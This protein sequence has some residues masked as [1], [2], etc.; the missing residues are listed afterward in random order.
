MLYFI[1]NEKARSGKGA[2]I[3][4]EVQGILH[5]ENRNYKAWVT[6]YEGHAFSLAKDICEKDDSDICLVVVGGDG[7]ANE[8]INGISHFEKVR[9]GTIPTGSGNDLAR[10]L[11]MKGS[12]REH[13]EGILKCVDAGGD[14]CWCM[15]LG[16]VSWN[17]GE[18]PRLFAISAGVGL[19]ALVC[20]KALKSRLKDFLNQI[21]LGKLT[22]LFLT[23]QS[24]FSMESTDAAVY[25]NKTGQR[26]RK[27][28]ICSAVMNFK[29]EGGGVPMAPLADAT[30][31]RL[32]VCTIWGI[33]KW[34]TFFCLPLLVAAKHTRLKGFEVT[35]C[36]E[37]GVKLK[38]P[39][40][41][42][43][44]GEYCGDVTEMHFKCLP[45]KLRVLRL[46]NE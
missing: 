44:D 9:F 39:M 26:N 22:Y 34:R 32:S 5:E 27:H 23:I 29:A 46:K 19:D 2:K 18:K 21:H 15:D 43:A 31:G 14:V 33:K 37:C 25:F 10:G 1:I 41:L 45:G 13:L 4:R 42:H 38:K 17:G 11:G 16:Q 12:P 6:E 3:W 35:N 28:M 36:R 40:V 7:T 20:K 8:V 24:L 30:D